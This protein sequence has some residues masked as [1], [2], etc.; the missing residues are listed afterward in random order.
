MNSEADYEALPSKKVEEEFDSERLAVYS[1]STLSSMYRYNNLWI[2][3]FAY[4]QLKMDISPLKKYAC[5]GFVDISYSSINITQLQVAFQKTQVLRLNAIDTKFRNIDHHRGTI[6]YTIPLVWILDGLYIGY[7]E[8]KRWN[9]FFTSNTLVDPLWNIETLTHFVPSRM[10]PNHFLT[11][12]KLQIWTEPAKFW[13]E[14][15]PLEFQMASHQDLWK[16]SKLAI[17]MEPYL[18]ETENVIQ[19]LFSHEVIGINE[20]KKKVLLMLMLVGSLFHEFPVLVLQQSLKQIFDE[21]PHWGEFDQSPISWSLKDRLS[22]LGIL[23]GRITVDLHSPT[24]RLKQSFKID[25]DELK[26]I[27]D[28]CFS[29]IKN[30]YPK[31]PDIPFDFDEVSSF[32]NRFTVKSDSILECVKIKFYI[33]ELLLVCPNDLLFLQNLEK[34]NAI[35]KENQKLVGR[36]PVELDLFVDYSGGELS[37]KWKALEIKLCLAA[38]IEETLKA[39][40]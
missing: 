16:L 38:S 15:C 25:M 6:I 19:S 21:Y 5:L 1:N 7:P 34:I 31:N 4:C 12:E 11:P 8:R 30:S 9:D 24:S 36:E 35:Y 40:D 28:L 14:S 33:L 13:I 27:K 10:T 29:Y 23:V 22:F 18:N 32:E 20:N 37:C 39:I 3:S 17:A 2:I 26:F